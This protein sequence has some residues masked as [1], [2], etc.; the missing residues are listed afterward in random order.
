MPIFKELGHMDIG[1]RTSFYEDNQPAIHMVKNGG[2]NGKRAKHMDVK[3]K[4]CIEELAHSH[5]GIHTWCGAPNAVARI[6]YP[7]CEYTM[8]SFSSLRDWKFRG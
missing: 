3:V 6:F 8:C 5:Y 2:M 4:Y 7:S 1:S